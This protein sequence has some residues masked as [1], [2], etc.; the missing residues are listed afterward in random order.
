[1][2]NQKIKSVLL[3]LLKEGR[4]TEVHAKGISMYP[5]LRPND[6]LLVTPTKAKVGDIAVF[7]RKD[8]LVAHRV[9]KIIEDIY[10]L[11][12]DSLIF[13]DQ[14]IPQDKI[15]GIV[16][17]RSRN[18]KS[19]NTKSIRFKILKIIMPHCTFVLGRPFNYYARLHQKFGRCFK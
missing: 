16:T 12:G 4:S 7:D 15:L 17:E 1:M 3:E 8:V 9:Y 5:L 19:V 2:A 13:E 11:K 14:P 10:F 18:G 6:K